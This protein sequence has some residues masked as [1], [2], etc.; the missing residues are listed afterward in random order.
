MTGS[1]WRSPPEVDRSWKAAINQGGGD[2]PFLG[3]VSIF[4]AIVVYVGIGIVGLTGVLVYEVLAGCFLNG[5]PG[6]I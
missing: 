3:A 4:T 1:E 6:W 5:S 2:G